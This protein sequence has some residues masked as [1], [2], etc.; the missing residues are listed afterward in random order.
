MKVL[1]YPLID[2]DKIHC[3]RI[4]CDYMVDCLF[5][6][7]RSELG[8][9]CVDAI[10]IP[11]WYN[12]TNRS[13]LYGNG[14]TIYGL[15]DDIEVDRTDI[16]SKIANRYY[17]QI[18]V[19]I[20]NNRFNHSENAAVIE[21]FTRYGNKVKIV[22]G[23]DS[24]KLDLKLARLG[25]YFKRE[26][27]DSIPGVYPINFC[28]PEEKIID[29]IPDKTTLFSEERPN[30]IGIDGW[31]IKSEVEYYEK[32][33]TALFGITYKKGG[34]DSMRH[35]EILMNG[36]IPFF[37]DIVHCPNNT[38][39]FFPKDIVRSILES[40]FTIY[41]DKLTYIPYESAE[42]VTIAIAELISWTKK[43]LTTK[44]IAKYVLGVN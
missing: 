43:F 19:A 25:P 38:M 30:H 40:H 3:N 13:E 9:D 32:Y 41:N 7:L 27:I 23:N 33:R 1:F 26:L 18:I 2:L 39:T 8:A 31:K 10:K 15:L 29:F 6:G 5:H 35:Y 16:P 21:Q 14:F 37:S 20:H 34:W 4:Y 28:V 44:A 24:Q 12:T 17:D 36:C 11:I 42:A 22:C